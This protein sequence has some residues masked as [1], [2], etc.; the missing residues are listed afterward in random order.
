MA[1]SF[2]VYVASTGDL[3][4]EGLKILLRGLAAR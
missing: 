1:S 4:T 2:G 3:K